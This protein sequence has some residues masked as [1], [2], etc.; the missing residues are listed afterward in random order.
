[1][2]YTTPKSIEEICAAFQTLKFLSTD[3]Q[4][5]RSLYTT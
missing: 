5:N 2:V 1:M 3:G 4:C